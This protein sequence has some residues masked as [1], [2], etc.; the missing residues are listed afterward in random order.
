M[1][2]EIRRKSLIQSHN[3]QVHGF[4]AKNSS[5]WDF[6]SCGLLDT[7]S[8]EAPWDI[9]HQ[10]HQ[11]HH[12]DHSWSCEDH[13]LKEV[14]HQRQSIIRFKYTYIL[15]LS[16]TL[17]LSDPILFMARSTTFAKRN[18][19]DNIHV[20]LFSNTTTISVNNILILYNETIYSF[21]LTLIINCFLTMHCL[22]Q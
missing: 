17:S 7:K 10:T 12:H 16:W 20:V 18:N 2:I 3:P 6:V 4:K 22:C 21:T 13:F 5:W 19:Q 15:S 11:T 1:S 14:F 8:S 9:K